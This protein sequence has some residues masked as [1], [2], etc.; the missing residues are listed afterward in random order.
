M[1]RKPSCSNLIE[2]KKTARFLTSIFR[3]GKACRIRWNSEAERPH[4]L[5]YRWNKLRRMNTDRNKCEYWLSVGR[6]P[7]DSA[8]DERVPQ[9]ALPRD[10]RRPCRTL[11]KEP[12]GKWNELCRDDPHENFERA[13]GR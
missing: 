7:E 12:D 5:L 6:I 11:P 10:A 8:L 2:K 13:D 1:A 9:A 4:R 3:P